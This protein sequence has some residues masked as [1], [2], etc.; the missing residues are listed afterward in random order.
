MIEG[1]TQQAPS[2]DGI[3]WQNGDQVMQYQ[4]SQN[5]WIRSMVDKI[6]SRANEPKYITMPDGRSLADIAKGQ[7]W[8]GVVWLLDTTLSEAYRQCAKNGFSVM[9]GSGGGGDMRDRFVKG[10]AANAGSGAT[11][12][13][14]SFCAA[15]IAIANH[16]AHSHGTTVGGPSSSTCCL[17]TCASGP[18]AASSTHVHS[19][20][21]TDNSA[22]VHSIAVADIDTEPPYYSVLFARKV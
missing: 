20:T 1:V 17:I 19:V 4:L 16:A 9:D 5:E 3:D 2:T 15:E 14:A 18:S 7:P 22:Q 10:A 6:A 21:I 11:G 8:S 12:G 13:R